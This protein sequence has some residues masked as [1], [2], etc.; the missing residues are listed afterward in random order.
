MIKK[1]IVI[2]FIIFRKKGKKKIYFLLFRNF[3]LRVDFNKAKL[4]N[5][6]ESVSFIENLQKSFG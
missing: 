3:I 5:D 1:H 4:G 6:I 2:N